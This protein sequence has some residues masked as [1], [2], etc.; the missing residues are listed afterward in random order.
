MH[1]IYGNNLMNPNQYGFTAKMYATDAALA[2]KEYIEEGTREGHIAILVSLDVK[3]AL[4]AAWWPSIP[5]TLKDF[6]CPKNLYN[7]AKSY[8]SG[9]TAILNTNSIQIEKE[10]SKDYSQ[11]SCCG[12]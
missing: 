4:D 10:V 3:G 12:P 11:G 8:F 2:I 9:R 5:N 1:H 7:L 6:N